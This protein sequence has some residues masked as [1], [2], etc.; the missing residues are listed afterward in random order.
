MPDNLRKSFGDATRQLLETPRSPVDRDVLDIFKKEIE[1][2]MDECGIGSIFTIAYQKE[3]NSNS[4]IVQLKL[5]GPRQAFDTAFSINARC[6]SY[7]ND[8]FQVRG[9]TEK[10]K[11]CRTFDVTKKYEEFEPELIKEL[12]LKLVNE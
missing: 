7:E 8:V 12:M 5:D 2:S 10:G 6:V 9:K 4:L 1:A 11:N 3:D